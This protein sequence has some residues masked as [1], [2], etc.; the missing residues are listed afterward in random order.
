MSISR[1]NATE[2]VN[3]FGAIMNGCSNINPIMSTASVLRVY[4]PNRAGHQLGGST[5]LLRLAHGPSAWLP[6]SFWRW[7]VPDS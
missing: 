3:K 4:K 6:I 1:I 5:E 2:E 7:Y